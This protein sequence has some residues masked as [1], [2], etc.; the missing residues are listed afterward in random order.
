[1][2]EPPTIDIRPPALPEYSI[3]LLRADACH[4]DDPA[5]IALCDVALGRAPDDRDLERLDPG[6]A[7]SLARLTRRDAIV[8]L[9]KQ[10]CT[11]P[12]RGGAR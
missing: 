5:M 12:Q 3:A 9:A 1:M 6:A 11:I 2:T 10:T 4:R 7:D 8:L